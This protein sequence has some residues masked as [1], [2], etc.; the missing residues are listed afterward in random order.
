[1][2]KLLISVIIAIGTTGMASAEVNLTH[3]A[4]CHGSHFEKHALGKSKIVKDLNATEIVT[5]LKGYKN[6]TYGG[7]LKGI[8]KGQISKYNDNQIKEI[9]KLISQEA[10]AEKTTK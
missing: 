3:C 10:K 8:M 6:G 4:A 5:A 7:S 1:M 9:A 2:K